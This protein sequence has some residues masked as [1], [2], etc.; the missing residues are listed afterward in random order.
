MPGLLLAF[1]LAGC[2]HPPPVLSLNGRTCDRSPNLAKAAP[3][4]APGSSDVSQT[5]EFQATGACLDTESGPAL[6]AA[7]ALPAATQPYILEVKARDQQAQLA[8][9]DGY[10][11]P[12][13]HLTLLD[14]A[15]KPVRE[16][17]AP[18]FI[19]RGNGASVL[20]RL[21]AE[22]RFVLIASDPT[23]VG[24]KQSRITESMDYHF[25]RLATWTTGNENQN[26][27]VFSHAGTVVVKLST[28]GE[29]PKS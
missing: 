11:L 20:V 22:E 3:L 10:S 12:A 27:Y 25:A 21:H 9:G 24:Q 17:R 1:V 8:G 5:V 28:V 29:A 23:L 4:A 6:Y 16:L 13:P 2:S 14:A 15:G 19:Y 7:F 26:D 18:D